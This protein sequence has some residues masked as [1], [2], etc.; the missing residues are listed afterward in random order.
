MRVAIPLLRQYAF[1]VW[2]SLKIKHY[3]TPDIKW[4]S[5]QFFIY[6]LLST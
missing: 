4:N 1:M 2:G 6:N 3:H 5:C